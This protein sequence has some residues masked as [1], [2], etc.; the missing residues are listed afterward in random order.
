MLAAA[1]LRVVAFDLSALAVTA[2]RLRV[3]AARIERR[4]VRDPWPLGDASVGVLVASLS[5]HYFPWAET[6]ALAERARRTLRPGGLLLCR[7]NASDDVNFGARGHR[8]I[9]RGLYDVDG[10]PKRFFGRDDVLRMFAAGW[11]VRSLE[12]F[13]S[14]KYGRAKALWEA[15]L[16]RRDEADG[17]APSPG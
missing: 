6:L 8:E 12:P 10:T 1:G 15:V 3:P 16:E 2:A 9:E 11:T 14:R 4:D 7:L 5:L 17:D 13:R